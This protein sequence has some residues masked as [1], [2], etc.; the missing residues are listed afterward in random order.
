MKF[1]LL[2]LTEHGQGFGMTE[3]AFLRRD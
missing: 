3:P 1:P 2:V